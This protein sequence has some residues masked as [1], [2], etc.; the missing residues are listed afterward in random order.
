MRFLWWRIRYASHARRLTGFSWK[1]CWAMSNA[2]D[3][4][5]HWQ[6]GWTPLDSLLEEMSYWTE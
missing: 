3:E 1:Q 6:E 4:R 2:G 5:E